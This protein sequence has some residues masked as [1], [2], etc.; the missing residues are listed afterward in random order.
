M[1]KKRILKSITLILVAICFANFIILLN[2]SSLLFNPDFVTNLLEN[3][4]AIQPTNG[5]INYFQ[6]TEDIPKVFQDKREM[7]HLKDVKS[8]I[9]LCSLMLFISFLVCL[10]YFLFAKKEN[11]R[12][13][14]FF[15][16]ILVLIITI[17][18]L[19]SPFTPLFEIFHKILFTQGSWIFSQSSI[20]I[21]FYPLSF[22]Q[23]FVKHVILNSVITAMFVLLGI[24]ISKHIS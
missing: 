3:K 7:D 2:F 14:L 20:L 1:D 11:F 12:R 24:S 22:F 8:T 4:D 6:D 13:M 9:N 21:Q 15:G 10:S 18:L 17:F 5:L 16:G 23:N 19:V